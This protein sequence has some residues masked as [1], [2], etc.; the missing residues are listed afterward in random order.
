MF[1]LHKI[2]FDSNIKKNQETLI[3]A[4]H[5]KYGLIYAYEINGYGDKI[6]MDDSNIPSLLS[7]PYLCPNDISINDS[8]Y[9]NTRK[10]VL[11]KDNPWFFNG[12]VLEGK[13]SKFF[14]LAYDY[15][16]G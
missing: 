12:S 14:F 1:D 7:L 5:D 15:F 9:Q 10:F 11:S 4:K 6:L 13:Y 16:I 8:I 3:T 2:L